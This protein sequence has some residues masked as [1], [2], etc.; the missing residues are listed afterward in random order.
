MRKINEF[1][2]LCKTSAK[3]LRFYDQAG[4]LSPEYVDPENGYRY[5]TDEQAERYNQIL[6]LKQAGFTLEEI[7]KSFG[8]TDD[9]AVLEELFLVPGYVNI[10]VS[11]I[12]MHFARDRPMLYLEISGR[13]VIELCRNLDRQFWKPEICKELRTILISMEFPREGISLNDIDVL[14]AEVWKKF[15]EDFGFVWG[16]SLGEQRRVRVLGIF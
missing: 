3:T 2:E 11:D 15:P 12:R 9:T 13:D 4:V 16:A 14:T 6:E 5:Y 8:C 7:K 10:S 1:A